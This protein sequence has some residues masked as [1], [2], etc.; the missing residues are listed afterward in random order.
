MEKREIKKI[1]IVLWFRCNCMC[2]FCSSRSMGGEGFTDREAAVLLDKYAAEGVRAV[3][4]GGGEPTVR[5]DLPILAKVAK[6]LGYEKIGV[7]SN[8]MRFCYPEYVEQCM[9]AGINEY[10]I[11]LWGHNPAV[12]D[13]MAGRAGAF[14]MTE[15]GMKHLVDFGADVTL[16][17]LLTTETVEFL[18]QIIEKASVETGIKKFSVW[19]FSIFGA[20]GM[21][22]ELLPRMSIAGEK[23]VEAYEKVRDSAVAFKTSHI[24][25]CCL[26]GRESLYYNVRD[27]RLLIATPGSSFMGEE[28]P[29]EAGRH[30]KAC[31]SCEYAGVCSGPRPEYLDVF[32][33]S[34]FV[35][36]DKG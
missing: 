13:M 4:F 30:V 18:P 9:E 5:D 35:A 15:M 23:V 16:D 27:I 34:E 28:S 14:E 11:S 3:D 25:P 29:F 36:I 1:E 31:G 8:G 21:R 10:C 6:K 33:D 26:K 22:H 7:K 20:G 17:F 32:G 12:H 19:L 2:V 24:M